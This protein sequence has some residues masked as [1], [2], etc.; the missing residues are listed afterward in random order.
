V[1]GFVFRDNP[2]ARRLLRARF[3]Q[4]WPVVVS[5]H[6]KLPARASRFRTTA[7][8]S[9]R[10]FAQNRRSEQEPSHRALRAPRRSHDRDR[11]PPPQRGAVRGVGTAVFGHRLGVEARDTSITTRS[12]P[13]GGD[14]VVIVRNRSVLAISNALRPRKRDAS[15][16]R[17]GGPCRALRPT[18]TARSASDGA[19][20]REELQAAS[21]ASARGTMPPLDARARVGWLRNRARSHSAIDFGARPIGLEFR[22]LVQR[23]VLRRRKCDGPTMTSSFERTERRSF[24][25]C[26]ATGRREHI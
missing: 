8:L 24:Q 22:C 5:G 2:R 20:M 6:A 19:K 14:G 12:N 26:A 1:R 4:Q 3:Q 16:R 7:D 9:A 17:S 23:D 18:I 25:P 11:R 15:A 21:R 10:D 13:Q